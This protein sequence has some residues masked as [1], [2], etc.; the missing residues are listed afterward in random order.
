[1][2]RSLVMVLILAFFVILGGDTFALEPAL[3]DGIDRA[4]RS[5]QGNADGNPVVVF[6][7]DLTGGNYIKERFTGIPSWIVSEDFDGDGSFEAVVQFSDGTLRILSQ[8]QGR[9]KTISSAR[10]MAPEVAPVVLDSFGS[11]PTGGLIGIDD[12]G[13]LVSIDYETGRTRRLAGGFSPLSHLAAGDF[14]KDGENEIAAV[15]DEGH[16][17]FV[18]GKTKTRSDKAVQLLPDTRISVADLDRD[19]TL[20][21]I[22]FS[23]PTIDISPGRLGDDL[24]AKGVAVFSWDGRTLRLQNEFELP[25]GQ[26]FETLTPMVAGTGTAEDQVMMIP[27]KEDNKGTQIR[28]Y[29]Y[30]SGRVRERRKGPLFDG[31]QWV[32]ILGSSKLGKGERVYL[33]TA[34]V[35][36]S[37]EGDLELYRLDLAQTRITL[38]SSVGTHLSGSRLLESTLIGDMDHDGEIELLAPGKGRSSLAIYSLDSNRLKRKEI[39]NSSG[40]I[41][42][43]LCPGDFNGDGKSDVMFGL[44]DGTLVVLLGE[45]LTQVKSEL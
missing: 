5:V 24:E 14:D 13:D 29:T 18:K 40:E 45:S 19:G 4:W 2:P 15:S 32:H 17:T 8:S 31:D 34:Q 23:S 3:V 30:S 36:E 1:M 26:V 6:D 33:I 27:V 16:M 28:S 35:P 39:F 12:R 9:F 38:N 42:T 21:I 10:K 25:D 7:G 11:E 44:D 22:A 37:D 43:N 41:G 20:E